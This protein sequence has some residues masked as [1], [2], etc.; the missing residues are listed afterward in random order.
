MNRKFFKVILSAVMVAGMLSASA[1]MAHP[2]HDYSSFG[3]KGSERYVLVPVDKYRYYQKKL[4]DRKYKKYKKISKKHAHKERRS[5]YR[6]RLVTHLPKY[7]DH[8]RDGLIIRYYGS[9]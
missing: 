3:S 2:K 8:Y 4:S 1:V 5:S 6:D 7:R 9:F